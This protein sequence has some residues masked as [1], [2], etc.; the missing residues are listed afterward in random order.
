[1]LKAK[2]E[3][4]HFSLRYTRIQTNENPIGL[5]EKKKSRICLM[6]SLRLQQ[7]SEPDSLLFGK[8]ISNLKKRKKERKGKN[9]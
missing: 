8:I 1:M 6:G 3:N 5:K 7:S 9:S 4:L 2:L